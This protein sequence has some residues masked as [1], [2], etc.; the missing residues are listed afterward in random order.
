MAKHKRT[1]R[2]AFVAQLKSMYA[3]EA[4]L[5]KALRKLT[6]ASTAPELREVLT[7]HHGETQEHLGRLEQVFKMLGKKAKGGHCDGIAGI[8]D[9]ARSVARRHFDSSTMDASLIAAVQRAEHYEIAA[10]GTLV[11][12][13]TALGH[14]DAAML[15]QQTLDEEKAANERLTELADDGINRDAAESADAAT[16]TSPGTRKAPATKRKPKRRPRA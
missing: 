5:S 12:W 7:A 4:Q 10:Y 1:L 13:A 2:R 14:A 3:A 6:K 16:E 8:I 11:A 15:L 9:D